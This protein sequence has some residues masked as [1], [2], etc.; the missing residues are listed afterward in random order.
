[1]RM[2][3]YTS[4][5][6]QRTRYQLLKFRGICVNCRI[7]VADCG[8]KCWKC[9]EY[10]TKFAWKQRTDNLDHLDELRAKFAEGK[11]KLALAA[12]EN[13]CKRCGV[14]NNL[15]IYPAP[16]AAAPTKAEIAEITSGKRSVICIG[17]KPKRRRNVPIC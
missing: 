1:M 16:R 8:V 15:L 9:N 14:G 10:A 12:G 13:K 17:C 4:R 7:R 3:W 6:A 2:P 11:K 5:R